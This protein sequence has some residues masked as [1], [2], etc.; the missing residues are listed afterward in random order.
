MR[1]DYRKNRKICKFNV[2]PNFEPIF[3]FSL[4]PCMLFIRKTVVLRINV[5]TI[6]CFFLAAPIRFLPFSSLPKFENRR[7]VQ[8]P[9][10]S[11]KLFYPE[12]IFPFRRQ[13]RSRPRR[14]DVRISSPSPPSFSLN[15][16]PLNISASPRAEPL[17]IPQE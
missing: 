9:A 12:T 8:A 17:C 5:L 15:A 10:L 14:S 4:L 3:R 7:P 6:R 2:L 16:F 1:I 13:I 11:L